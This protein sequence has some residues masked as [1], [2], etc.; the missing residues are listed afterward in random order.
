M[1]LLGAEQERTPPHCCSW[2]DLGHA[3]HHARFTTPQPPLSTQRTSRKYPH[4]TREQTKAQVIQLELTMLWK[5]QASR[6]PD[7]KRVDLSF[8]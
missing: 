7:H 4:S 2:G 6:F 5:K 8:I 1:V 3:G